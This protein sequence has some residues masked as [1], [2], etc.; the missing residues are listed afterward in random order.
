MRVFLIAAALIITAPI[1]VKAADQYSPQQTPCAEVL[2]L[3][4][5]LQSFGEVE[6]RIEAM[7]AFAWAM[8][9]FQGLADQQLGNPS[10]LSVDAVKTV[11]R[12]LFDTC[13][14]G[15]FATVYDAAVALGA[16]IE[17]GG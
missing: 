17:F 6:Q 11:G 8:G 3:Q 13:A 7:Q 14:N 9:Y 10:L 16:K 12:A 15:E 4:G 2:K 1:L 5:S